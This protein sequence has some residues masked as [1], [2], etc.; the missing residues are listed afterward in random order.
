MPM[1]TQNVTRAP[2]TRSDIQP[3]NGRATEP[4]SAPTNPSPA[5]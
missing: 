4:T 3:P 5:R 2:P 1:K